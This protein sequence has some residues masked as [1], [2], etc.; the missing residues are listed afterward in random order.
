[1]AGRVAALEQGAAA[2]EGAHRDKHVVVLKVLEMSR[3]HADDGEGN[4][5]QRDRSAHGGGVTR[6]A[7]TPETVAE[8]DDR[9]RAGSVVARDEVSSEH[10]LDPEHGKEFGADAPAVDALRLV[11]S[12]QRELVRARNREVQQMDTRTPVLI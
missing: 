10:G 7:P 5:I 8:H 2:G 4:G 12:S 11:L 6:K 9:G 3:Q 1:G